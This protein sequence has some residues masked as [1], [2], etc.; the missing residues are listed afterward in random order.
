MEF[1][2]DLATNATSHNMTIIIYSAND[3]AL[4]PHL[5]SE[6]KSPIVSIVTWLMNYYS[7]HPSEI[8]RNNPE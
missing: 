8:S 1:L 2:T 4:I 3:D 6:G 7:S 5:G